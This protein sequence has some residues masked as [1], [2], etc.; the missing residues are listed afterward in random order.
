M[1]GQT[2]TQVW[3]K[4][5]A[6]A[7]GDMTARLVRLSD[8]KAEFELEY[9]PVNQRQFRFR[10]QCEVPHSGEFTCELRGF[11]GQLMYISGAL[12]KV[13]VDGKEISFW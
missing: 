9:E 2:Y 10:D 1:A 7:V 5:I 4:S 11:E 6:F 8:D 13:T 12:P 3:G